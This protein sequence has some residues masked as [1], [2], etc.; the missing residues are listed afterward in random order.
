GPALRVV[1]SDAYRIHGEHAR[2]GIGRVLRAEDRYLHRPVAVKELI[3]DNAGAR[4]RFLREAELTARLQHPSIV[5]I[6]EAGVWPDGR[7]FYAMKFITGRSL[8]ELIADATT[9]DARLALLPHAIA[10]AEAITYAHSHRIIHRDLKPTNVVV[11]EF[12]ETMVVDWGLGKDLSHEEQANDAAAAVSP[13]AAHTVDGAVLGTPAFMSPEQAAGENVDERADIYSIGAILYTVLSGQPPYIGG[14]A[15]ELLARVSS[16]DPPPVEVAHPGVPRDL[17][18]I[19]TRAMA[20]DRS[21][22]YGTTRE[23]AADLK[24]FQTGQLVSAHSYSR[25]VLLQRF[26]KRNARVVTTA[27]LFALALVAVGAISLRRVLSERRVARTERARAEARAQELTLV[28]ARASLDRDPT[29]SIAWLKTAVIDEQS[30]PQV[31]AIAADAAARGVAKLIL[32][33]DGGGALGSPVLSADEQHAYLQSD[34]GGIF[35]ADTRRPAPMIR[36]PAPQLLQNHFHRTADG[37]H[38]VAAA[39]TGQVVDIDEV[40][41]LRLLGP[42]GLPA[43]VVPAPRGNVVATCGEDGSVRRWDLNAGTSRLF[44]HLEHGCGFIAWSPNGIM[45]AATGGDG[46]TRV[47]NASSGE[48]RSEP[49]AAG[50]HQMFAWAP[51][52]HYVVSTASTG[53]MRATNLKTN[54][55]TTVSP[56]TGDLGGDFLPDDR[57]YSI[58]ADG[59]LRIWP[60]GGNTTRSLRIHTA[61]IEAAAASADGTRLVTCSEDETARVW[62]TRTFVSRALRGHVQ[63]VLGCTLSHDG[64]LAVTAGND[65]STRIWDLSDDGALDLVGHEDDVYGLAFS[66]DGK[67]LATGDVTSAIRV[68]DLGT[69]QSKAYRGHRGGVDKLVFFDDGI[70]LASASDDGTVRVWDL[71]R[72]SATVF[73]HGA[74]IYGLAVTRDGSTLLTGCN[75]GA[76]RIWDVAGAHLRTTLHAHEAAAD[77]VVLSPDERLFASAGRD[78]VVQLF[79]LATAMPLHKLVGHLGEVTGVAFARGGRELLSIGVDGTLREWDVRSGSLLHTLHLHASRIRKLAVA[80]DGHHFATGGDDHVVRISDLDGE[81]SITLIGHTD[82]VTNVDFSRDGRYVASVGRDATARVW[83]ARLGRLLLLARADSAIQRVLFSPD[84]RFIAHVG[85][86]RRVH[87]VPLDPAHF[88]PQTPAGLRAWLDRL[89]SAV[90][91]AGGQVQTR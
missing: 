81:S 40:H 41:G 85:W 33:A 79:D 70:H 87:V 69:G 3:E 22:R 71:E 73:P 77:H 48:Q 86:D 31:A 4:R 62:D 84:A 10:V 60:L 21:R 45:L 12:G 51:S 18:A 67:H 27:A 11:G 52:G 75:D 34:T 32:R 46:S 58:S 37:K 14:T 6:Y 61:K 78:S 63:S 43:P 36:L 35:V 64:R 16:S 83:D 50:Q 76:V 19:V 7:P 20:R 25:R 49:T 9:L 24:R 72:G 47:W 30:W 26:L 54:A 74:R 39:A 5:P 2:G 82:G 29:A 55:S 13:N 28:Q 17:A 15:A 23:L 90:V 91:V 80:P 59:T 89:T 53:T 88:V 1:A 38:L 68:W 56:M 65:G 8:K 66:R 44:G 42:I 57:Y